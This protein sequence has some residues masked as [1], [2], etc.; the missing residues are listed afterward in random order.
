MPAL[1]IRAGISSDTA[2][3]TAILSWILHYNYISHH[4]YILQILHHNRIF[5]NH[6]LKFLIRAPI[7]DLNISLEPQANH[8]NQ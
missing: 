5:I 3:Q 2:L 8:P 4:N 1:T 6:V 7:T